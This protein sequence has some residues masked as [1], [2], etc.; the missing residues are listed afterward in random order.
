M[1]GRSLKEHGVFGGVPATWWKGKEVAEKVRKTIWGQTWASLAAHII[2]EFVLCSIGK[3]ELLK[4]T[5][6]GSDL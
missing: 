1:Q 2:G 6:Q 3:V 4:V 5:E